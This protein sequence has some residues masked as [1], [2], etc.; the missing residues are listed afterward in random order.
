MEKEHLH[1]TVLKEEAVEAILLTTDSVVVDAT[2]GG[3]G[4][5]MRILETLGQKGTLIVID[6]DPAVVTDLKKRIGTPKATLHI[7]RENFRNIEKVL[8]SVEVEKADGV[9]ADLG[10]NSE[11]FEKSGKGFSFLRDEPLQM[12]FGDPGD[13]AFTAEDIVNDWPEEAIA[14]VLYGYADERYSRG[15]AKKICDAR[16]RSRI[17]TTQ[18][19]VKVIESGV[20]ARYR[21]GRINPATKTF[22]ALRI[23]VND[24]LDALTEF[25][26]SSVGILSS[27]GRLAI[28]T[29][30]SIEDRI[31]KHAFR[32][33]M[34]EGVGIVISKKPITP[35]DEEV[36]GNP[37]ARSAKLRIFQKI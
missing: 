27:D 34:T 25:I 19:L 8:A 7:V 16:E 30:H 35:S 24:E 2:G 26:Q 17:T 5:S 3:G 33:L 14:N 36:K 10:W 20:P 31:V 15:I 12:T 1:R 21:N 22:Q 28:I 37:R 18:E 9:L 13:Y 4:H 32:T 6:S 29:F 11:Q 23:A